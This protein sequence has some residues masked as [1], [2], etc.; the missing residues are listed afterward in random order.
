MPVKF[1]ERKIESVH[2]FINMIENDIHENEL[3]PFTDNEA[4][5]DRIYRSK[6][7]YRGQS[8]A[9][10]DLIPSAQRQLR[11]KIKKIINDKAVKIT[12]DNR[13]SE[14][15]MLEAFQLQARPYLEQAPKNHYTWEWLAL[16]QHYNLPTR[17]LDWT[18]RAA[19]ALYFAVE[20]C[21]MHNIDGALWSSRLFDLV[22][23]SKKPFD[24]NHIGIYNPPHII[25]RITLQKGCFTVHPS[26]YLLKKYQWPSELIKY[27]IPAKNKKEILHTLRVLGVNSATI[28]GDL[29]SIALEIA[30]ENRFCPLGCSFTGNNTLVCHNIAAQ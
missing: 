1:V 4:L 24:I 3:Q 22:D 18:E 6:R 29:D 2:E 11:K 8:S 20:D 5:K 16:A 14:I 30:K 26:D 7:I 9:E 15:K 17:L 27:T 12:A 23:I 28:Y 21:S 10:W 19:T 25:S 13:D